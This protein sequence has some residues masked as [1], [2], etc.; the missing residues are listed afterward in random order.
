VT[1][2]DPDTFVVRQATTED[3]PHIVRVARSTWAVTYAQILSPPAVEAVFEKEYNLTYLQ[4]QLSNPTHAIYVAVRT[5][6]IVGYVWYRHTKE[7]KRAD[8]TH[9]YVL[10]EY[11]CL[12]IGS[13]FLTVTTFILREWE[14]TEVRTLVAEANTR[15][16]RFYK[17]K[18]FIQNR[19]YVTF[20]GNQM[21]KVVEMIAPLSQ[22]QLDGLAP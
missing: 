3:M 21:L 7:K 19:N 15:A 17:G 4:R 22:L 6:E 16:V 9:I 11:Q 2:Q 1:L 18:G 10:P 12:G 14:V 8:L 20:L 13:R 5:G